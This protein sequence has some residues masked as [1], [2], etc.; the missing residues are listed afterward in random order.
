[1]EQIKSTSWI[2]SYG[3]TSLALAGIYCLMGWLGVQLA[4]PTGYATAVFPSSGIALAAL[5]LRGAKLWPGIFLGQFCLILLNFFT[6]SN[7]SGDLSIILIVGL[8]AGLGATLEAIIALW[9]IHQFI[10]A[11]NPLNSAKGVL[12]FLFF[13]A[14]L[15]S[16]A[17]ATLGVSSLCLSHISSWENF[18][19]SW[20]TWW[21]GDLMGILIITPLILY[22]A[23]PSSL[24][25]RPFFVLEI[26]ILLGLLVGIS[27]YVFWAPLKPNFHP[28]VFL[29]LPP[30]VWAGFRFG[31]IGASVSVLIVSVSSILATLQNQGPFAGGNPFESILL[32]QTFMG[33][34]WA[35]AH[36]IAAAI[37]E[38][39]NA[40]NE[41]RK[42]EQLFS[43]IVNNASAAIYLKD[44]QGRY[45][46]VNKEFEKLLNV[47]Q[48]HVKGKTDF[49]IFPNEITEKLIVNDKN[50]LETKQVQ[51]VEEKVPVDKNLRT[52]LSTK[53]PVSNSNGE[54]FGVAGISTDITLRKQAESLL[55]IQNHALEKLAE[56]YSLEKYMNIL[57]LG[58][59]KIFPGSKCSVL[60]LNR[61]LQTLHNCSGPSL[62]KEFRD[63]IDGMSIGPEV[64]SCGTAAFKGEIIIVEDIATNP[65]WN[66]AKNF[67]L[68][69]G[70]AS[71]WSCP[72]L[73]SK[74]IVLGTFAVYYGYP[75]KPQKDELDIIHS[76]AHLA[77][78][79]IENKEKEREL[80]SAHLELEERVEK[81]TAE[82]KSTN[83]LLES[84][85]SERRIAEKQI[86]SLSKFP[87]ENPNPCLRVNRAGVLIYTNAPGSKLL[88]NWD[89]KVFELVPGPFQ[90]MVKKVF[91]TQLN[92]EFEI[93]VNEQTKLF[94]AVYVPE[95][96]YINLYGQDI[97][98]R[99][100]AAIEQK[101]TEEKLRAA[102]KSS[103]KANQAKSEFL[104]RMSHE[105]RTPMNAILGFTQLL[106]MDKKNP[107]ADYQKENMERVST[108][109]KYLLELINETL[110]LAKVEAGEMNLEIERLEMIPIIEN[111]ITIS[112]PLTIP[113]NISLEFH[114]NSFSEVFVNVDK[115]RFMQVIV[116]LISNAIKY[117]KPNG[118]VAVSI[119]SSGED[120]IRVSVKDTGNGIP[121]NQR[122]KL[123][124][125]FERFDPN[126]ELI[127]GTGIGLAISK[128]FME[129]LKGTIGFESVE[130]EGSNFF[131]ELPVAQ[132][133]S[134]QLPIENKFP[135][136]TEP[137]IISQ[138]IR[139]ILYI[140]DI[141]ANVTLV[142]KIFECRPN[143]EIF[144][145]PNANS[146]I[147]LAKN[148]IPDLILM[149][150]QLPDMNGFSAL[151]KLQNINQTKNIP[152]I[153][154]TADAMS[155]DK[156]KGLKMGFKDY[157]TK[158]IDIVLLL[159]KVDKI[160]S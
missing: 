7:P 75:R 52:Y 63:A 134:P 68:S 113:N 138:E 96:D 77:R 100:K 21:L 150:I 48:E 118:S 61:D 159:E 147:S 19:I 4:A 108:A 2:K 122:D 39:E 60:L 49:D 5:I 143:I 152:V 32:L 157:L 104:A 121:E 58:Y 6:A 17:S 151:K 29:T 1:M 139:K 34:S 87:D 145:A 45:L 81:R 130:G 10:D 50:V 119:E 117:N 156:K 46:L 99:K 8:T 109:G 12:V 114:K 106:Q 158:P 74:K 70:L 66:R 71:S 92:T 107:L 28:L 35:T 40:R 65:L 94:H 154:L 116:N 89:Y 30:I 76:M 90:E 80:K 111:A 59:E 56:G 43:S 97:T 98:E 18:G 15:S 23:K 91:D 126:A 160:L 36:M 132:R 155:A 25:N 86:L 38:R 136:V 120:K 148:I 149:D 44:L 14:A 41:L 128:H 105:L 102:V 85:I 153:A 62:P 144:S 110:D 115:L 127:E 135:S 101:Q 79:A 88:E 20:L 16:T 137:S 112:R 82:L 47:K 31:Q 84:E 140:E 142:E 54:H 131:V 22:L 124:V 103:E 123:F 95:M 83:R 69:H 133:V 26:T 67:A 3:S 53:F 125:P 13:A 93:E 11:D 55:S 141:P 64:G 27:S 51:E 57:T 37:N 42:N 78:I 72:I 129:M 73:N 33:V 24:P 146:G 9:F